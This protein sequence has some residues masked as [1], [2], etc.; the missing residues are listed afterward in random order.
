MSNDSNTFMADAAEARPFVKI[1]ALG[2]KD[3]LSIYNDKDAMINEL[4]RLAKRLAPGAA[5]EYGANKALIMCAFIIDEDIIGM[6]IVA[7]CATRP[8]RDAMHA[9]FAHGPAIEA[10]KQH[11]KLSINVIFDADRGAPVVNQLE[12]S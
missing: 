9:F 12:Q 3:R 7:M 8:A 5:T 10:L 4:H 11:D 6:R 1:E 2:I